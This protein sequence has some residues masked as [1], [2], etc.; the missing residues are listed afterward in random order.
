MSQ[1]PARSFSIVT[2]SFRQPE[3]LRLCLASVADQVTGSDRAGRRSRPVVEITVD[4]VVQDAASGE[5]VRA[6]CADFPNVRLFQERDAGMYDAVNRGWRR[7]TG[8]ICAYLNCDEQFLPGTLAAVQSYF[9]QHPNVELLFGDVIVVDPHGQ[10]VCSRRVLA[11]RRHHTQVCQLN[12]F[13]AAM[14]FRRRLLDDSTGYFDTKWRNCGDAVWVLK[15]IERG[16]RMAVLRRYLSVFTDTG[17]NMNLNDEGRQEFARL[18]RSAAWWVR[19]M[20]PLWVA[21]H[22]GRRLVHGLYAR[23]P[24]DYQIYTLATPTQR[25]HFHVEKSRTIWWD[26]LAWTR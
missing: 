6:V 11:P 19:A 7:G 10:Y 26:R 5:D 2:P 20:A 4:H 1:V 23:R 18:R 12:T 17:A 21:H 24:L 9:A 14:F 16:V 25:A 13:T 8:D 15:M 3:W 22:R